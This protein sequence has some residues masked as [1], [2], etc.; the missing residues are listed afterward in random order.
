[1]TRSARHRN[2]LAVARFASSSHILTAVCHGSRFVSDGS[3]G[4]KELVIRKGGDVGRRVKEAGIL[5]SSGGII[6]YDK[7]VV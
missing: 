2:F 6:C 7:E 4:T 1:V 3:I 5:C